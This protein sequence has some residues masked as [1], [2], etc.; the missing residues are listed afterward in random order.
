MEVKHMP[1]LVGSCAYATPEVIG[2]VLAQAIERVTGGAPDVAFTK[3]VARRFF[4]WKARRA[5]GPGV[6]FTV[7]QYRAGGAS[8][9]WALSEAG[10]GTLIL[11]IREA[12]P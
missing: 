9:D 11:A 2:R 8:L 1:T 12:A 7:E 3:A 6:R 5:P 10:E 4:V